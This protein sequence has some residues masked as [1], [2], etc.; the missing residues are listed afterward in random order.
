MRAGT[1]MDVSR[2]WRESPEPGAFSFLRRAILK[3]K[4]NTQDPIQSL[5]LFPNLGETLGRS[6]YS[7]EL[8]GIGL[9]PN[10]TA[11]QGRTLS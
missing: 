11:G 6:Q 10:I 2:P 8:T 9:G 3:Q 7:T 5:L 1:S 4:P